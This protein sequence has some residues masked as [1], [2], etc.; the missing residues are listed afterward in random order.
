MTG[1]RARNLVAALLLLLWIYVAA[2][3]NA[4]LLASVSWYESAEQLRF[5]LILPAMV[6]IPVLVGLACRWRRP[7]SGIDTLLIGS[8][9]IALPLYLLPLQ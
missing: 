5:Y 6:I 9:I 7:L 8:P 2:D 4:R 1:R 3:L